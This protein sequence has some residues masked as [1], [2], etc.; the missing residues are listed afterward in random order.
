[1]AVGMTRTARPLGIGPIPVSIGAAAV[2]LCG[3]LSLL[4][5]AAEGLVTA[6]PPA[7]LLALNWCCLL[8]ARCML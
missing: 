3:Q 8:W 2:G 6:L 5:A 7:L 4:A 1:M